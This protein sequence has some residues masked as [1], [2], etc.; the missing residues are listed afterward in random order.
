MARM[1]AEALYIQLG[2][3][4]RSIPDL[5]RDSPLNEDDRSWLGRA[6]AL[7]A[8]TRDF[9]HVG[10]LRLAISRLEMA[11]VGSGVHNREHGPK[12]PARSRRCC[13]EG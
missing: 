2:H 11:P 1:D 10:A 5:A 12:P 4:V 8:E 3:L 9:A 13:T 6:F 7:V